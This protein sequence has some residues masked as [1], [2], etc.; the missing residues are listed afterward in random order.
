MSDQN[1]FL[2]DFLDG[3][4]IKVRFKKPILD[5]DFVERGMVAWF[6]DFECPKEDEAFRLYFNFKEFED[7]NEKYMKK[8]YNVHR[9][10]EGEY[11]FKGTAR[12]AGMYDPYYWVDIWVDQQEGLLL[13]E[14][15]KRLLLSL[16]ESLFKRLEDEYLV[17]LSV[18][19][20]P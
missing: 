15:N 3:K 17:F 5:E 20:G 11:K 19:E 13:H 8:T 16:E 14:S 12:D 4:A 1:Y 6:V 18:D 7:H 10:V 2:K 9:I